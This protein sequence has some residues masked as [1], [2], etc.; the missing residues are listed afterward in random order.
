MKFDKNTRKA[1]L[2]DA[3]TTEIIKLGSKYC[4]NIGGPF[5]PTNNLSMNKTWFKRKW[6]MVVVRKLLAHGLSIP[7]L[8]SPHFVSV[9]LSFPNQ[10]TNQNW[11][12]KVDSTNE[13]HQK[14][15]LFTKTQKM[16][17]TASHSGKKWKEI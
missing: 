13:K 2:T 3:L 14:R 7:L 4:Q 11:S 1:I 5:L 16:N 6:E 8:R 10:T 9:I 12:S 15:L 17:V